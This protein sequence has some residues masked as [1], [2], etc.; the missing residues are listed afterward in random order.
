MFPTNEERNQY[1]QMRADHHLEFVRYYVACECG[2]TDVAQK[3]LDR[4]M[5]LKKEIRE[6]EHTYGNR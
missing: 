3:Y 2:N 6:Y 4:A 1:Y 5:E